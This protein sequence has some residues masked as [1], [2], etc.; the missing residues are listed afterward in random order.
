[1]INNMTEVA[2]RGYGSNA[3]AFISLL[4]CLAVVLCELL[5][6]QG[7]SEEVVSWLHYWGRE[8]KPA[9]GSFKPRHTLEAECLAKCVV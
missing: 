1:M 5:Q 9:V 8:I 6:L 7:R 2:C 4:L 3:V